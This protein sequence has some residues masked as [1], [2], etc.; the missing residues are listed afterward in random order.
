MAWGVWWLSSV[1]ASLLASTWPLASATTSQGTIQGIVVDGDGKPLGLAKIQ[2][3]NA[4]DKIV[5]RTQSDAHGVFT[6]TGIAPGTYTVT[7]TYPTSA[8]VA[9]STSSPATRASGERIIVALPVVESRANARAW[10]RRLCG[11][12]RG[13]PAVAARAG[14]APSRGLA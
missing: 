11:S 9:G 4:S 2:L 6:V 7:A 5:A 13:R 10:R 1:T 12:S 8:D 14:E 3:A